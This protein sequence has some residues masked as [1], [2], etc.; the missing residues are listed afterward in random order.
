LLAQPARII[1]YTPKEDTASIYNTVKSLFIKTL[2]GLNGITTQLIKAK[3]NVAIGEATNIKLFTLLGIIISFKTS[4]KPS[5]ND[6]NNPHI[7]TTSGPRL[8]CIVP[9]I[10][11][12]ATVKKATATNK[13]TITDSVYIILHSIR[14]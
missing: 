3:I 5:A 13:G 10:F 9:I 4:F 8:R 7:P 14:K 6:C 12:S 1:P 11:L 2:C